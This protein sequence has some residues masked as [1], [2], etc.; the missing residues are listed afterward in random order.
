MFRSLLS[1]A[2]AIALGAIDAAAKTQ[3]PVEGRLRKMPG[4]QP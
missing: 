3:D 2:L 4:L 1:L